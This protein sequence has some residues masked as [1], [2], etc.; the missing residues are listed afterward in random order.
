MK[1]KNDFRR[2]RGVF[3]EADDTLRKATKLDPMRRSGK[4]RRNYGPMDDDDEDVSYSPPRESAYD[5]FED[6]E[7]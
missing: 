1:S 4:E 3:N 7:E 6:A 5:Y 2:E